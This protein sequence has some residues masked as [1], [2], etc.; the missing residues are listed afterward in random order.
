MTP[1]NTIT[2]SINEY[3]GY[4]RDAAAL[5]D[6]AHEQFAVESDNPNYFVASTLLIDILD[7][8]TFKLLKRT[9]VVRPLYDNVPADA[10][11]ARIQ[12]AVDA[13]LSD[14]RITH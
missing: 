11:A 13:A 3:F 12:Q 14:L 8:K 5:V 4:G 6:K 1:M 9:Y 7:S 2:T 10:R